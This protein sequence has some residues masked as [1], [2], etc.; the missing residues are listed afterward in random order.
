MGK[1]RQWPSGWINRARRFFIPQS[2]GYLLCP[3]VVLPCFKPSW[4][5]AIFPLS[6]SLLANL[7][8]N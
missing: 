3:I 6:F 2:M 5:A 1:K 7:F 4:K 8:S